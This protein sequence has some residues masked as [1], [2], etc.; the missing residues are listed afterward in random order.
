[1]Q[2]SDNR[3]EIV[4]Y[5]KKDET[6]WNE[7]V[8]S[9]KN[10]LFLFNRN[11][12]DYHSDRFID[13]SLMFYYKDRLI[14]LLPAHVNDNTMGS[15]GGLTFGG[16]IS[17]F[18]MTTPL[19][20]EVFDRLIEYLREVKIGKLLYKTVPYIYHIVP[21]EEDRYALFINNAV[22][23]RRDVTTTI[24][25]PNK[26]NF[27]ERRRRGIKK[28]VKAGLA[29]AQS[30]D[31]DTFMSIVNNTLRDKYNTSAVHTPGELKMLADRFKENI[32]LFVATSSGNCILGG[33]IV[34]ENRTVAHAQY[35]SSTE[36]GKAQGALDLIFDFL[37]N[38]YYKEK[39]YFDFGI[40]N[41]REGRYLNK[42]LIEQKEGFGARA[43][44]HDAYELSVRKSV[45][46][47]LL[48]L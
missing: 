36:E 45:A 18:D 47:K 31:Y 46:K 24:S 6:K 26:V 22:L 19:M 4:R 37:I 32:K 8:A 43:V 14:G 5:G 48:R 38:G 25:M 13:H 10:G 7:F 39:R 9:S 29:V 33:V 41:E 17:G 20:L 30:E 15:H 27:Q 40:S 3:V 28:A 23:A 21:S 34:Y 16:I 2:S 11:Y 35:I 44:V 42:E 1:M 12:M